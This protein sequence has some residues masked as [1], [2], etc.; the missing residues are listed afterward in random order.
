MLDQYADEPLD[1]TEYDTVYHDRPVLLAIRS[2]V[3]DVESLRHLEVE[4][5]RTALPCPPK[6]IFKMEIDLGAVERSVTLIDDLN[7]HAQADIIQKWSAC[8]I[9]TEFNAG[10]W[11]HLCIYCACVAF[12]SNKGFLR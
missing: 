9:H 10:V 2:Y 7:L 3:M 6:R 11:F 1:G 12:Y 5:D 4:L 8:A